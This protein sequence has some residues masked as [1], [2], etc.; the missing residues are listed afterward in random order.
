MKIGVVVDNDLNGDIRVLREIRIL[1]KEGHDIYVLCFAFKDEYTIPVEG[2]SISRIR[3]TRRSKN[4]LFFF[5]NCFPAYEWLWTKWIKEFIVKHSI[6]ILH[7]HDL[8]MSRSAYSGIKKS[9]KKIPLILDLHENYPFTVVT[10]NWT[11]GFLRR[12]F[13]RPLAWKKKEQEYLSYADRII[14]LSSG[15]REDLIK[16]YPDI[17][18]DRI[19][20]FP[21]APD[22]SLSEYKTQTMAKNPFRNDGVII[23]YYGVI[24][25]RRGIFDSLDVFSLIIQEGYKAN[26]LLIGPVDKMDRQRFHTIISRE[27]ISSRIH[28]IPWINSIDFPSYLAVS[29][30]CLAPFKKNPQHESG[31]ANKIYDYMLGG[32]PII[33]S[34]CKPQKEL[35]IN[36]YSGLI[37]SNLQE[38]H[39]VLVKLIND[40]ST[41]KKMGSNGRDAVIRE[42]NT[43]KTKQDLL[44][45]YNL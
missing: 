34:D 22:L 39:D 23:F 40:E 15:Y 2:I 19:F 28:Y 16:E 25:E 21:N 7:V 32:K 3:I 18:K 11:K 41:R 6:E 33:A 38:F 24:A 10:Y 1:K 42:L 44:S 36:T 13:S 35:I 26:F 29:D 5:L 43:D 17:K 20:V 8:Y 45:A 37:Y 9:G 4:S 30:I 27:D 12:M 14:V 31:I